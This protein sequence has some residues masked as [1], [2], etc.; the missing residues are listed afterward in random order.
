MNISTSG[1]VVGEGIGR[2]AVR[3]VAAV[4]EVGSRDA[5]QVIHVVVWRRI[6]G[7]KIRLT[8][9]V[10]LKESRPSGRARIPYHRIVVERV[11]SGC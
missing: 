7:E 3:I 11:A 10:V 9:Q 4:D 6:V 2:V 8:G 5:G 1:L